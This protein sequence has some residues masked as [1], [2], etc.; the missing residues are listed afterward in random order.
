[1]NHIHR[2]GFFRK[3]NHKKKHKRTI[4]DQVV[5]SQVSKDKELFNINRYISECF[6]NKFVSLFISIVE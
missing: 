1:M 6:I 3:T 5:S 2:I 4:S